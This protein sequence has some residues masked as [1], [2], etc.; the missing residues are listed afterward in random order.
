VRFPKVFPQGFKPTF[1]P[2]RLKEP[3]EYKKPSKIFVCSIADI[4]ASWTPIEWRNAILDAINECPIKHTFQLLTKNPENIPKNYV[5]PDNVWVGTT[6]TGEN[7][8]WKNIKE[9]KKVHAK[10]CFVSFEPLLGLL[11]GHICLSG[12]Q[13][14]IIGKLTGSKRVKL[15]SYWVS[16]ILNEARDHDIPVFIKNNVGWPEK[17]QEF[18]Q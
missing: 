17:V 4:F 10:V 14:V 18:P 11:P 12:L 3:S 7:D 8:D 6:V 16:R 5:F 9:I 1:Y 2:E 13:W 15:D